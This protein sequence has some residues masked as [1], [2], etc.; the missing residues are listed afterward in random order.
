MLPVVAKLLPFVGP[1]LERLIPN[2]AKAEEAKLQLQMELAKHEADI[3]KSLAELDKG[4][5]EL[6]RMDAQSD[7]WIKVMWRPVLAWVCVASF[8]WHT[9]L[10]PAT[11]FVLEWRGFILPNVPAFDPSLLSTVLVGILG[12]GAFRTY[13]KKQGITK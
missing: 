11:V 5:I 10:L 4:Q 1:I 13:E 8:A 6:N 2:K 9:F 12:L 3:L 7:S